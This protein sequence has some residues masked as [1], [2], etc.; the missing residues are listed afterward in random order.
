MAMKNWVDHEILYAAD[1]NTDF[2]SLWK[3]EGTKHIRTLIDRAVTYSQNQFSG[4]GEAYIDS[5]GRNDSVFSGSTPAI[6]ATN[7]MTSNYYGEA[8]TMNGGTSSTSSSAY[9]LTF[10]CTKN[11]TI[12]TQVGIRHTASSSHSVTATVKKNGTQIAYGTASGGSS[13]E[14]TVNLAPTDYSDYCDNGD[15]ITVDLTSTGSIAQPVAST[16][17]NNLVSWTNQLLPIA[18]S[19]GITFKEALSTSIISHSIPTGALPTTISSVIGVPLIANWETGANIEYKL[20]TYDWSTLD[21]TTHVIIQAGWVD[22]ASFGIN[23]CVCKKIAADKYIVWCTNGTAN[24]RRAQ[25]YKTLFY[26]DATY[27]PRIGTTYTKY[28]TALKTSVAAD[29]GKQVHYAYIMS[30][31][32]IGTYT[33]TFV[34]T[35]TNTACQ[36]WSSCYVDANATTNYAQFEAPSGTVLNSRGPSASVGTTSELGTDTSADN[37]NNPATCQLEV[38]SGSSAQDQVTEAIILCTG[39]ITWVEGGTTGG[40]ANTDFYTDLSVPLF[41][42][43][44][45]SLPSTQSSTGWLGCGNAPSLSTFTAFTTEPSYLY[46]RLTPGVTNHINSYPTIYGFYVRAD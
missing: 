38:R 2:L 7:K 26:G 5:N 17:S 42:A 3:S 29:V 9:T 6:L 12:M 21:A 8:F 30:A 33:G 35:T 25:I 43:V 36:F 14:F 15:T 1:L 44:T 40:V 24:V 34:N 28:I 4:W 23:D 10:T 27:A 37:L 39:D 19:N 46:V 16:G 18:A 13:V 31:A 20:D 32:A 22:T 41:T 45:E 11:N